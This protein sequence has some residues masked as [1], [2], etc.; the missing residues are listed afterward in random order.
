V[1][2]EAREAEAGEAVVA[3]RRRVS[4]R[5]RRGVAAR[6]GPSRGGVCGRGGATTGRER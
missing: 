2:V 1:A 5:A 6:A 3:A 4:T